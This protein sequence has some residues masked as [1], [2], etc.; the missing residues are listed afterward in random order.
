MALVR[1]GALAS[2]L[3]HDVD[4]LVDANS[5]GRITLPAGVQEVQDLWRGGA[6]IVVR[7]GQPYL[8]TKDGPVLIEDA[9]GTGREHALLVLE[10]EWRDFR[11]VA[12]SKLT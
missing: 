9:D 12:W 3:E 4:H 6:T 8:L 10:R 5:L 1:R 2:T 7:N 11:R